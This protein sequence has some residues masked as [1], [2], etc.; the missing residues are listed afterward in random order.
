MIL[1]EEIL[2]RSQNDA[3]AA[4]HGAATMTGQGR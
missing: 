3:R 1:S 4:A 2:V